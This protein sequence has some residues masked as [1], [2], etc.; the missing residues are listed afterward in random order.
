MKINK[1]ISIVFAS[2][3]A[4]AASS[5]TVN[6]QTN[7]GNCS[8]VTNQVDEIL[9]GSQFNSLVRFSNGSCGVSGFVC[10]SNEN[11]VDAAVSNRAFAAALTAQA[12]GATNLQVRWDNDALGCGGN[13]PMIVDMRLRSS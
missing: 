1:K 7:L 2:L 13:F 10:F 3:L 9:T 6:A 8:G 11:G 5:Q 12:T 4:V